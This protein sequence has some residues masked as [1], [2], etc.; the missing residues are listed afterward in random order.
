V[1]CRAAALADSHLTGW[2]EWTYF[3]NG[4]TDNPNTP[5]LVRDPT[6]P[7]RGDNVDTEQRAALVRPYARAVTGIPTRIA[8]DATTRRFTLRYRPRA[9]ARALT[10]V[11]VPALVYPEGHRV[12]VSGGTIV[13]DRARL[14]GVRA[15]GAG[16]VTVT[17]GPRPL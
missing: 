5:S 10:L 7:P 12:T 1:I 14:I 3:S 9:G 17:V 2:L 6:R 15:A 11:D 4:R 8:F 16:T 13:R